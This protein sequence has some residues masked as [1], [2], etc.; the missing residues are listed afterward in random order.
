MHARALQMLDY[1]R[2]PHVPPAA[3]QRLVELGVWA[4]FEETEEEGQKISVDHIVP[5]DWGATECVHRMHI[6]RVAGMWCARVRACALLGGWLHVALRAGGRCARVRACVLLG[7]WLHVPSVHSLMCETHTGA[8]ACAGC[9]PGVAAHGAGAV[10]ANLLD[11]SLHVCVGE[12]GGICTRGRHN[13]MHTACNA[14]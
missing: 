8:N 3:K 12:G 13:A 6:T 9:A 14:A 7:G 5:H 11:G 2:G 4:E 10:A 1:I